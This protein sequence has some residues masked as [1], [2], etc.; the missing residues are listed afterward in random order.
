MWASVWI[1]ELC[2]FERGAPAALEYAAISAAMD[3][4][5]VLIRVD[6]GVG[7]QTATAWGCDLTTD[8]V[9]INGDYTT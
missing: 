5:E 4:P 2:A 9:H 6:L 3:R 1:S 8:Y 7:V